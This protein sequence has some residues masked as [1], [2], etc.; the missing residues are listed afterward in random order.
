LKKDR[1]KRLLDIAAAIAMTNSDVRLAYNEEDSST[2]QNLEAAHFLKYKEQRIGRD[3]ELYDFMAEI[4]SEMEMLCDFLSEV[5]LPLGLGSS[6]PAEAIK[7]WGYHWLSAE[8]WEEWES[9]FKQ[10]EM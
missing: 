5:I 1:R 10:E 8:K 4:S 9:L 3:I 6:L 2:K 7:E